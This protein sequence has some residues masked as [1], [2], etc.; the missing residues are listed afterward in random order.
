MVCVGGGDPGGQKGTQ[1]RDLKSGEAQ[2]PNSERTRYEPSQTFPS[3]S[4]PWSHNDARLETH[5][6]SPRAKQKPA[7]L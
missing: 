6:Q 7:E 5:K 1:R 3:L 4:E 2:G